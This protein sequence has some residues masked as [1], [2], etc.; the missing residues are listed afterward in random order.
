MKLTRNADGELII[1]SAQGHTLAYLDLVGEDTAAQD[2]MLAQLGMAL[3]GAARVAVHY[4]EG[5]LEGVAADLDCEILVVEED[6][7]DRPPLVLRRRTAQ[8]DGQAVDTLLARVPLGA[9]K[10]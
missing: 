8:G 10:P 9:E 3:S 1:V 7:Y 2:E 5:L 6:K 4:R